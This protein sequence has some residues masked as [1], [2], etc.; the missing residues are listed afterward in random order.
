MPSDLNRADRTEP[1]QRAAGQRFGRPADHSPAPLGPADSQ[2]LHADPAVDRALAQFRAAVDA[3]KPEPI[4]N[5]YLLLRNAAAGVPPTEVLELASKAA[6]TAAG[7]M[8]ASAFSHRPCFMCTGGLTPCDQCGG[9]GQADGMR[10]SQCDG[11][12][13]LLCSFCHGADWAD[14]Q[15]IPAELRPAV[16]R[17]QLQHLQQDLG[18]LPKVLA[19]WP[20]HKHEVGPRSGRAQIVG[21]LTRIAGRIDDL[22]Q[23]GII[24]DGPQRQQLTV[25]RNKLARMIAPQ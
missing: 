2:I 8:V 19:Q 24:A 9:A 14:R 10:C 7:P 16:L 12:G 20:A 3:R 22:I 17:K 25:I 4:C 13:K 5:A 11:L 15:T 23:H 1:Q 21:F 6:G 18:N